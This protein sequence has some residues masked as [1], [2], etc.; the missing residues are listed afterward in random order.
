MST[1][2]SAETPVLA[3]A[4]GHLKREWSIIPV[5]HDKRPLVNWKPYQE[6]RPTVKQVRDWFDDDP[7][8]G[9]AIITGAIS[10]IVVLDVD[11]KS[12]G[13]E[14]LEQLQNEHGHLPKTVTVKTGGGGRHFYFP[15]PGGKIRPSAGKLGRGLDIRGDGAYV[16]A[17]PSAHKS[18]QAYEWKRDPDSTKLA[19]LPKWL[20]MLISDEQRPKPEQSSAAAIIEGR[21]NETLTSLAGTMQRRGFSTD[22][23][24]QALLVENEER[25]QLPLPVEEVE[26]IVRSIARYEPQPAD[27]SDEDPGGERYT[28][29]ANAARLAD[30]AAGRIAHVQEMKDKWYVYDGARLNLAAKTTVIPFVKAV[31]RRLYGDAIELRDET[32]RKEQELT[33]SAGNLAKSA[34][35]DKTGEIKT[36]RELADKRRA[37]AMRLESRDG[38]YAAIELAK[39]EPRLHAN[40]EQIDAH[41]TWLNT[42]TETL[43]LV[44]GEVW[45]HRSEDYLTRVT[46]AAYDPAASCPRWEA[47]LAEV[48]PS[49]E[50]RAFMQRSV[51]LTLTDITSEQCL[52]FLYGLGRNG[53]TTFLNAVRAVLGDYAAAVPASTLMVKAHGD[54]K[55][56]DVARLRGARFVAANE[57]EDGQQMAEALIKQLTGEDPI[58]VRFLFAEFFEFKPTFKIFL[59][60]NHKPAIRGQDIAMWRR[61]H[62]VPFAQ[63]IPLNKVDK[64]LPA[65]LATEASGILNWAIAGFKA[66]QDGGLRPPKEV[67]EATEAYKDESD[68][69]GEFFDEYTVKD[70]KRSAL[71]RDI[72]KEYLDWVQST[73]VRFPMTQQMLGRQLQARGFRAGRLPA[74]EGKAR[75]WN[76]LRLRNEERAGW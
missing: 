7:E 18:G 42:P 43:D 9:I 54:D 5:G 14:S 3:A 69:L 19:Q 50:V 2:A 62:V 64:A 16:V 1:T 67:T 26:Q 60:A 49:K 39:A 38:C 74:S 55:R 11:A 46:A 23:I 70:P 10:G 15:H 24:L 75:V 21:R 51:G 37:G 48:I 30:E 29:M 27:S 13:R 35:D 36:I 65:A 6:R 25:C 61:I 71:A 20:L 47:F 72:Y 58:T 59:A 12:D 31:A 34:L 66:W 45:E 56:N 8:A 52:W 40:L 63:T 57:A 44:T 28:D 41:P 76:G 68:P 22:A 4:L 17:P 73:G 32:H 33:Q 53:K